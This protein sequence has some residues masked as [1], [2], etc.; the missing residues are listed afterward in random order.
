MVYICKENGCKK[1]SHYG[2]PADGKRQYCGKHKLEAM[3]YIGGQ[4]QCKH[5][6]CATQPS[7]GG[8]DG[9]RVFCGKHKLKGMSL[10]GGQQCKHSGCSTIPSYGL[11][12][13]GNRLYCAKHKSSK[14]VDIRKHNRSKRKRSTAEDTSVDYVPPMVG[15][16]FRCKN[17]PGIPKSTTS[18]TSITTS[19]HPSRNSKRAKYPLQ[20][21]L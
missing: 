4:Q 7:Y 20:P 15:R 10:I 11:A 9:K 13:T 1:R 12:S 18:T 8:V 14:M 16:P 2:F 6:G 19:S 17:G 3:S 5:G 21:F